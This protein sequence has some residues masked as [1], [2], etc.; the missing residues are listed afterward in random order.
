MTPRK[1]GTLEFF[2]FGGVGLLMIAGA[3]A[4]LV[5]E[6]E[7]AG[8][9]G[10]GVFG[11]VFSAVGILARR[12]LAPAGK[13]DVRVAARTG[14]TTSG[15]TYVSVD[16]DVPEAEVKAQQRR[17]AEEPWT[18]RGD[19]AEG[20]VVQEGAGQSGML[21]AFAIVWNV[22]SWG[23]LLLWAAGDPGWPK[24]LLIFPAV[25][26]AIAVL[27][28]RARIREKKFGTSVIECRTMPAWLGERFEGTVE[29]GVPLRGRG[30]KTFAV[31]LRC[32]RRSSR[33]VRGS[34]GRSETQVSEETLWEHEETVRGAVSPKG[35]TFQVRLDLRIPE[36][37]PATELDPDDDRPLWRLRRRAE[38]EGV[39]Y[40]A[41]FEVPV[42][43]RRA[44]R[45]EADE[46][47]PSPEGDAAS[48]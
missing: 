34:D 35:P 40:A 19:W 30:E 46:G 45:C 20:K 36:S 6:G 38:D 11:L 31:R 15:A 37:L 8:A 4:L 27:A 17:W 44:E 5:L 2:V 14:D 33:T 32:V 24:M 48:A 10:L 42:Y 1:M 41:D 43:A 9:A 28:V 3:V 23:F 18:Q 7:F 12:V 13:K 39:D 25:G 29:T 47:E 16:E 26:V 22:F 21:I